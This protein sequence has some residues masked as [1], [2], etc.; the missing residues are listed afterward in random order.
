M[1][2]TSTPAVRGPISPEESEPAVGENLDLRYLRAVVDATAML[3]RAERDNAVREEALRTTRTS[4]LEVWQE[5]EAQGAWVRVAPF[6]EAT[7]ELLFAYLRVA[8]QDSCPAAATNR[9]P[10]VAA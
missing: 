3:L 4:L 9:V 8:S 10:E 7:L 2:R 1:F 6:Q 5:I